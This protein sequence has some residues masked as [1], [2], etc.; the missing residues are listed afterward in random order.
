MADIRF[1][2]DFRQSAG[3]QSIQRQLGRM[4]FKTGRQFVSDR[5]GQIN[6]LA[7]QL[8]FAVNGILRD[9]APG[10]R[11]MIVVV[12]MSAPHIKIGRGKYLQ[13]NPKSAGCRR[14]S[15][16]LQD[17]TRTTVTTPGTNAN[18]FRGK[19]T[20]SAKCGGGKA[21]YAGIHEAS[22]RLGF[23][24]YTAGLFRIIVGQVTDSV[25]AIAPQYNARVV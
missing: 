6:A 21:F 7:E 24:S 5:V 12:R 1:R 16:G 9:A 13:K 19:F 4:K 25:K 14:I 20:L 11:R 22:G 18:G 8:G 17:S 2:G 10:V 3:S 23:K 15:G